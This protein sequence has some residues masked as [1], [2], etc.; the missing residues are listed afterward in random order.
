ML[1]EFFTDQR[2][3]SK[4]RSP[5]IRRKQNGAD[6]NMENQKLQGNLNRKLS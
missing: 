6:L 3:S 1:S 2:K 5:L 4:L